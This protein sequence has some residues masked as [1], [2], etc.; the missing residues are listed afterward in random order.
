MASKNCKIG[1]ENE[2]SLHRSLKFHYAAPGKTEASRAGFICDAIGIE[3]EA[4]EVQTGS[5]GALKKK[6]PALLKEGK[7][8]VIYPVIVNKTIELYDTEGNLVSRKKSPQKGRAWDIF[9]ELIYA[10]ALVRMRGLT[11]EIALVNATERRRNDGKG[12]YHRKGISIEDRILENMIESI[13]LKK[14]ADWRRFLF[15][16]EEFTKKTFA[17]AAKIR[18]PLAQKAVYVLEKAGLVKKSAKQGRSWIYQTV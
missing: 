7:V 15:F 6:L 13:I 3:G 16:L 4:I 5:F 2:S 17:A 12:S 8:R 18:L 9:N 14:K 1:M 11:I 10:P